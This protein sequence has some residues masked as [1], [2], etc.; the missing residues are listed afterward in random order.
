LALIAKALTVGRAICALV[1]AGFPAE[2]FATSRTLIEI[3]FTIRYIANKD[4]E[5]RA[6]QYTKYHSRV[7]VEWK[8]IIEEHFPQTAK[9]LR[10]LDKAMLKTAQEFKSKAHWAGHGGQARMMA[11]EDDTVEKD[12]RGNPITSKFDYDA[13]YFWTSHYVHATVD[14]IGGHAC[15][16]GEV[17]KVR[18]RI[19]EDK[20]RAEDALGNIVMFTC[21]IF[22]YGLRAINEEQPKALDDMWKTLRKFVKNKRR[23]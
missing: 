10:P 11:L 9:A 15:E 20:D 16:S 4:T 19:W 6:R 3:F 23:R 17:F 12:E 21:K 8:K 1:D 7:R 13:L 5:N 2:A 18:A 22:V 14:G